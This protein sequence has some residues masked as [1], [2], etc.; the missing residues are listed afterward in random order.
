ME[1]VYCKDCEYLRPRAKFE[2][3]MTCQVPSNIGAQWYAK[4]GYLLPEEKNLN[5]DCQDFQESK[6][7]KNSKNGKSIL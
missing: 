2:F 3:S 1:K 7:G 4:E 6:H 5:N